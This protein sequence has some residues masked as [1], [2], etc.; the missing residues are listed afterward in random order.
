MAVEANDPTSLQKVNVFIEKLEGLCDLDISDFGK[1]V[2]ALRERH[3]FFH[4]NGCRLSD[5]GLETAEG[6]ADFV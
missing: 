6:Q 4:E 5:H 1:Y 2:E 3:T